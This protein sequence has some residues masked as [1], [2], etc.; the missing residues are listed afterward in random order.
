MSVNSDDALGQAATSIGTDRWWVIARVVLEDFVGYF[1]R[2][3]VEKGGEVP[4][5]KNGASAHDVGVAIKGS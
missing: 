3:N 4:V 5:G 2:T 1:A